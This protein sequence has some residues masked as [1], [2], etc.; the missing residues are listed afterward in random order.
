MS[1]EYGQR[2]YLADGTAVSY[3]TNLPAG[4][5]VTFEVFTGEGDEY[6]PEVGESALV[7]ADVHAEPPVAAKNEEIAALDAK[8][9]E[10]RQQIAKL[11]EEIAAEE[12][13]AKE[14]RASLAKWDGLQTLEDFLAGRITHF[15]MQ[16][17]YGYC[18]KIVP[19]ANGMAYIEEGR[20][21]GMRL[22][23]LY[24]RSNGDMTWRV[25][26]YYDGSGPSQDIYPANSYEQ[27]K[28]I[29]GKLWKAN[30]DKITADVK[31]YVH[32]P[33]E[34]I[35]AG[36]PHGFTFP[37]DIMD[38]IRA[39]RLKNAREAVAKAQAELNAKAAKLAEAEAAAS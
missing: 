7:V 26:R 3:I 35:K 22:L 14:R 8:I 28:E 11:R 13:S 12:R 39:Q 15:V 25:N 33:D 21:Q 27:A 34:W 31:G 9:A 18:P 16:N 6:G 32:N 37:D 10:R 23:S 4:H 2:V 19:F 5:V 24:G 38:R 17:E 20:A 1:F 29:F 36:A 30:I